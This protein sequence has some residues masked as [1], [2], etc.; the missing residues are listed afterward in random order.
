M[1]DKK[2]NKG[3]GEDASLWRLV[4]RDVTPLEDAI[5]ETLTPKKSQNPR[6]MGDTPFVTV[7]PDLPKPQTQPPQL[8]RR[9]DD[10]LRKGKMPIDGTID[11]H[12]M[13]Q[14]QA[15]TRLNQFL[16][17]AYWKGHRCVL[18][19]TGFGKSAGKA[20]KDPHWMDQK[21]GI[22]REKLP[23]WLNTPPLDTIVLKHVSAHRTHGGAGAFYVYLK[24]QK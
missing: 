14:N 13:T 3:N 20:E 9:T 17:N 18:V 10:K 23:H 21:P 11:L 24:R 6:P 22:L 2:K 12:G 16:L 4:T 1:T 19:I 7:G 5:K 15:H 8:D